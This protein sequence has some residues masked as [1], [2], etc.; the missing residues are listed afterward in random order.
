M[1]K[2][3]GLFVKVTKDDAGDIVDSET[4]FQ[5]V[6]AK[7]QTEASDRMTELEA[8]HGTCLEMRKTS[9]AF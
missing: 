6:E 1:A 4:T 5:T 8:K 7:N 2:Y 9:K 3:T